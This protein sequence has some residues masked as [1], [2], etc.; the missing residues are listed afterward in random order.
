MKLKAKHI[1]L[2]VSLLLFAVIEAYSRAGGGGGA[3][4][5][6]G[7]GGFGGGSG[8]GGGFGTGVAIGWLL[9]SSFGRIVLL[10]LAIVFVIFYFKG[11][12]DSGGTDLVSGTSY[13]PQGE[14]KPIDPDFFTANQNFN[15]EAFIGKVNTAFMAIQDAWMRKDLSK[16][17]KWISDGVYQR[18]NAQFTMMNALDQVNTLSNINIRQIRIESAEQEGA[19]SVIT[20]SVFFSLDDKFISNKYPQF[21][22]SFSGD[23]ATEYWTFIKKTSVA[24]KDLYHSN[25]CPKCG[26]PLKDDA[27][28]VSK[29]ESCGT[30]TYLGDYDWVLCEITQ[31]DDYVRGSYRLS[32]TDP[33]LAPLYANP[34]EHFCI[35]LMED[36][37]S[38]A[39][40]QYFISHTTHDLKYGHRFTDDNLFARLEEAVKSQEK[41]LFNR[42]YLNDVNMISCVQANGMWLVSFN[43]A[44]SSMRLRETEKGIAPIDDTV[45]E[46][47]LSL[48]LSKKVGAVKKTELWSFACP[49]CGAP[50]TDT[51]T[52]ECSYCNAQ[53][54]SAN[55]D[56]V[57][58]NLGEA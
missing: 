14:P 53:I 54:N 23:T 56:W 9:G 8:G 2:V 44:Y 11:R 43:I 25:N 10:I 40:M 39:I 6:G 15:Q 34:D 12:K 26:Y 36:K 24:E 1:L 13:G 4:S 22:E 57:M 51:T 19:Y 47:S 28:E 5:S 49:S 37:A 27:G 45:I 3:H 32:K 41:Y 7:G 16:V 46:R 21:N 20:A 31:E 17:R 48:T 35:Q 42:L 38:N 18:F 55:N 52:T 50:Y 29:C 58:V 33:N 30:V